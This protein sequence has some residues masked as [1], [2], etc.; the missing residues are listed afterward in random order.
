MKHET[1]LL[2]AALFAIIAFVIAAAVQKV[3]SNLGTSFMWALFGA[4]LG[5]AAGFGV[6]HYYPQLKTQGGYGY[7][8]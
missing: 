1:V 6:E 3:L 7:G 8:Y 5:V 4:I 2:L